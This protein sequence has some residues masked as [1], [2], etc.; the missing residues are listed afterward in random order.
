IVKSN[1]SRFSTDTRKH[2]T[3][4]VEDN[5]QLLCEAAY[6]IYRNLEEHKNKVSGFVVFTETG[7]TA[8]M[9]SRYRPNVP[10]YAMV[11]NNKVGDMLTVDHGVQP[12]SH[13][14][15]YTR[16]LVSA[17]GIAQIIEHLKEVSTIKKGQSLVIIYGDAWMEQ[18]K[19]S[20]LKLVQV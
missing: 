11:S 17:K 1:E 14:T 18:G 6:N 16:E 12:I 19:T 15:P 3:F 13:F 10:I 2:F 5:E 7:R 8:R 20:T 9:L 4:R